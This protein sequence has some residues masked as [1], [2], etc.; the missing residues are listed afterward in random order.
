[1]LQTNTEEASDVFDFN[2]SDPSEEMSP[3][4]DDPAAGQQNIMWAPSGA[5]DPPAASSTAWV[6]RHDK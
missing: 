6:N 4:T 2:S 5:S 3:V 1:M